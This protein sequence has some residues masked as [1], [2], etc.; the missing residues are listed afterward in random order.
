M[1]LMVI[2]T[3]AALHMKGSSNYISSLTIK[4]TMDNLMVNMA[5]LFSLMLISILILSSFVTV[6]SAI[7]ASE[8][9]EDSWNT[10][11]PMSQA[12]AGLGVVAVDGKIYAIGGYTAMDYIMQVGMCGTN[13]R[14]D[15]KTD[16]WVTLASMPTPR[17]NFAIAAYQ[18]KIYC[19]GNGPTEVYDIVTDS[20]S[21]KSDTPFLSSTIASAF[22]FTSAQA[23]VVDGK[24]FV[25]ND[26]DLFMYNPIT[27]IW[28]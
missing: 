3:V 11:A 26:W 7:S 22:A 15:P 24:I 9:V 18:G 6:L 13:E 4:K 28:T 2:L 1:F 12:R 10:K 17:A 21:V 5:K 25:I 14:Y 19:M 23:I 8:L 16:T 27:D 20:W